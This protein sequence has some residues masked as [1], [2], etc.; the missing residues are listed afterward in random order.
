MQMPAEHPCQLPRPRLKRLT[1]SQ[2]LPCT[3][4]TAA[5]GGTRMPWGRSQRLRMPLLDGWCRNLAA[6]GCMA[7]TAKQ[8]FLHGGSETQAA[9]HRMRAGALYRAAS[10]SEGLSLQ[11][12]GTIAS[13]MHC[14]SHKRLVGRH[15]VAA[16]QQEVPFYGGH[17]QIAVSLST[18]LSMC[19][20]QGCSAQWWQILNASLLQLPVVG[21]SAAPQ[22]LASL[23]NASSQ[24]AR[25]HSSSME[26]RL[27]CGVP[28]A[29]KQGCGGST[30]LLC[31]QQRRSR[32]LQVT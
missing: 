3:R 6:P 27:W 20:V 18:L 5:A 8:T 23:A 17:L 28:W 26:G 13:N 9:P 19:C 22:L 25:W 12:F 2:M 4:S 24:T 31:V 30:M 14:T 16:W 15:S 7:P 32:Y 1:G 29:H 10:I 11:R 21:M